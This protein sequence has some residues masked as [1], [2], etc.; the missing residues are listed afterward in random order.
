MNRPIACA[1]T[2]NFGSERRFSIIM[3]INLTFKP[4]EKHYPRNIVMQGNVASIDQYRE[5]Y[6]G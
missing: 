4:E 2:A 3:A 5:R 6:Y 1:S